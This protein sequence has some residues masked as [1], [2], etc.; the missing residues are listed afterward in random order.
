[1]TD[2]SNDI[3]YKNLGYS[4]LDFLDNPE[5]FEHYASV[6]D[7]W[8]SEI[9]SKI[10]PIENIM[11]AQLLF[12]SYGYGELKYDSLPDVGDGLGFTFT[13]Q[14][15]IGVYTVD[16]LIK[17]KTKECEKLIVIEC[18]GH[19]FHE[20]TKEQVAHDKKRDR[21]FSGRGI[22]VLRFSGSEIFKNVEACCEEISNHLSN[23]FDEHFLP[24]A[25]RRVQK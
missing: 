21:W 25:M 6:H 22:T 4:F 17:M 14:K 24:V 16:F 1:M 5:M 15:K 20:K 18:D 10:S 13:R 8:T 7:I 3:F 23:I 19:N 2:K 9:P 12:T 11:F